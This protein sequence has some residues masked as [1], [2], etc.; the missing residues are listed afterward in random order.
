MIIEI[1]EDT[2]PLDGSRSIYAIPPGE[3]SSTW[4]DRMKDIEINHPL[5]VPI[6]RKA[7]R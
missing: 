5:F 2:H 6:D 4:H 1:E 3:Q 7:K